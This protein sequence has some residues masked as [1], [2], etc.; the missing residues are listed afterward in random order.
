MTYNPTGIRVDKVVTDEKEHFMEC[1]VCSQIFDM[2]DLS[3]VAHHMTEDHEPE[4]RN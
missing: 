2:R 3:Q 1:S 4:K